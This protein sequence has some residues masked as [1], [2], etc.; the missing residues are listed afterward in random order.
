MDSMAQSRPDIQ[1]QL[2]YRKNISLG[3]YLHTKE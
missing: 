1:V 2:N 3:F